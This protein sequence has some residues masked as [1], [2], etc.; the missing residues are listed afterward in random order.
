MENDIITTP[1]QLTWIREPCYC[2]K[3]I[4]IN[5]KFLMFLRNLFIIFLFRLNLNYGNSADTEVRL[6]S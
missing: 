6:A 4:A 1:S 5:Y 2:K 3:I